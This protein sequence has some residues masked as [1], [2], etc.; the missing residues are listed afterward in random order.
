MSKQY[1]AGA[2]LSCSVVA[3]CCG[4]I[5]ATGGIVDEACADTARH[6]SFVANSESLIANGADR[7]NV[8]GTL[9]CIATHPDADRSIG[10]LAVRALFQIAADDA[11]AEVLIRIIRAPSTDINVVREACRFFVY[12][13]DASSRREALEFAKLSWPSMQSQF[14]MD[15]LR[16]LGDKGLLGWIDQLLIN[17]PPDDPLHGYLGRLRKHLVIQGSVPEMLAYIESEETDIDR[18]WLV[19]QA[20]R[21][22]AT[23]EQVRTAAIRFLDRPLDASMVYATATLVMGCDEYDVF[24]QQDLAR[25]ETIGKQR[26]QSQSVVREQGTRFTDRHRT[27]RAE[28]YRLPR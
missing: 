6:A 26:Q 7:T 3:Y 16:D 23:P 4:S 1:L 27:R 14:V 13:A 9:S 28:F 19:R 24:T 2:T 11:A 22:G 12:V 10:V 20:M 15:A 5:L 21:H 8:L 18:D 17:T 25:F